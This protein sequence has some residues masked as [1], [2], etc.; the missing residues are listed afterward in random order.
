VIYFVQ[1]GEDGP[2]KIGRAHS[3]RSRLASLQTASPVPLRLLGQFDGNARDERHLHRLFAHVRLRGEWF[4]PSAALLA[5]IKDGD[6]TAA[7]D[8]ALQA[9]MQTWDPLAKLREQ[10]A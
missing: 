2:I 5:V 8:E 7:R 3:P 6:I 9:E 1:V 4:E 10:G